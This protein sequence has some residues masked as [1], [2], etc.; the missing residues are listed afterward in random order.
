M[1]VGSDKKKKIDKRVDYYLELESKYYKDLS[2]AYERLIK[3][4]TLS[5]KIK[6]MKCFHELTCHY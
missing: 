6:N 5:N 2:N 3:K 1:K 4:S